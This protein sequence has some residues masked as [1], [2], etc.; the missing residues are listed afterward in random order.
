MLPASPPVQVGEPTITRYEPSVFGVKFTF[1][2]VLLTTCA[3][4]LRPPADSAASEPKVR[5]E[6]PASWLST[7]VSASVPIEPEAAACGLRPDHR[8][9]VADCWVLGSAPVTST[10]SSSLVADTHALRVMPPP[11]SLSTPV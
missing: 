8:L 4:T 2:C 11:D 10:T 1:T 6:W 9:T 3:D 7:Q 5:P